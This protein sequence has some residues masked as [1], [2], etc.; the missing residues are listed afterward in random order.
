MTEALPAMDATTMRALLAAREISAVE[1]WQAHQFRLDDGGDSFGAIVDTDLAGAAATAAA[2][3]ARY[4]RGEALGALAGVPMTIKDSFDVAGMRTSHGRLSDSHQATRDAPAVARAR[5]AD[6]L[7]FGKTNVPVLLLGYQT[8]NDDF[9]RTLNAWDSN[10]ASG[11]SSGGAA[12]AVATGLSA[13]ELGSDLAG[14][15]RVPAAW[16]GI[17]G[18]RPSNGV[19]SKRGHLPWHVDSR[20]EPPVSVS[21]PL[22]RSAR[23]LELVFSVVAG[24]APSEAIGWRLDLPRLTRKSLAGTRVGIWTDCVSAPIDDEMRRAIAALASALTEAGCHV[25]EIVEPPGADEAGLQLFNRMQQAEIAHSIDGATFGAAVDVEGD[26]AQRVHDAWR[27]AEEQREIRDEWNERVFD[28]VDVVIA[29]AVPGAAPVYDGQPE[30]EPERS[31]EISGRVYSAPEAV[32]AWSNIAN[33]AMLPCTVIPLG[34]GATSRM[35]LGA[36][37]MG[38]YLHDLTTIGFA[39]LLED[40]GLVQFVAPSVSA[41]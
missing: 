12:V 32:A 31:L 4:S 13:L 39:R 41:V 30:P 26:L 34:L 9:G 7:I 18:H 11:G 6:A 37:V 3:D 16:N 21:G 15:I 19:V 27:D 33:L 20:I 10:R 22:A 5:A 23:D 28:H 36:Q 2:I 24:A 14:S 25:L 35:P 8:V 40:A 38:P 1:L 29:P 17:F